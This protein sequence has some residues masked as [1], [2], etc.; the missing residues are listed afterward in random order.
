MLAKRCH[1]IPSFEVEATQN[2]KGIATTYLKS[3]TNGPT[4]VDTAMRESRPLPIMRDVIVV[5]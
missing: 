2:S 4:D 3:A 5:K 1:A